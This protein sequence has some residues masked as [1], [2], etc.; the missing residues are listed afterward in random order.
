MSDNYERSL[1]R[2]AVEGH[3][4]YFY[5]TYHPV[6]TCLTGL[7]QLQVGKKTILEV[8]MTRDLQKW[9]LRHRYTCLYALS[10][11]LHT[12]GLPDMVNMKPISHE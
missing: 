11:F 2:S 6:T 5:N 12:F 1:N 7:L 9:G 4:L 10:C 3:L 8:T